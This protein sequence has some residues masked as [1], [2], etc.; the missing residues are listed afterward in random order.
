MNIV[1]VINNGT[2]DKYGNFIFTATGLVTGITAA[3]FQHAGKSP[4]AK[5]FA[6]ATAVVAATDVV[7]RCQNYHNNEEGTSIEDSM[8][9]IKVALTKKKEERN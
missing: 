5:V 7:T 8:H 6:V 2:G 4:V 3:A 1:N 9:S